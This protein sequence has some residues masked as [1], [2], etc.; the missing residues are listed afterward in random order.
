MKP[1]RRRRERAAGKI[2]DQINPE[3][4]GLGQVHDGDAEGDRRD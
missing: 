1:E 2:G 4:G 3:I